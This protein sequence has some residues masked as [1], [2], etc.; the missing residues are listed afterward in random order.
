MSQNKKVQEEQPEV[1]VSSFEKFIKKYQKI[2]TWCAIG[3]LAIV[4]GILA[5]NR[6]VVKPAQEE[7]RGEMFPAEQLFA[8]GDWEKALNG[9]GNNLGFA[10]I[11]DEYGS[12]AGASVWLYAGI[13]AYNTGDFE[14]AAD[15][16]KKYDGKDKILKGRALC[17]LGDA[18]VNLDRRAEALSCYRKAAAVAD[19]LYRAGYLLKQGI[20]CEEMG[21]DAAALRCYKEIQTRYPQTL[22]GYEIEKYISRIENR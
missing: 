11:I 10:Q 6:W 4:F 14:A 8:A 9:D 17:C 18:Y 19:N 1:Q 21:D 5:V 12:K 22:E 7:A 2:L 3:I 16:L 13:C 20:L 15:Y